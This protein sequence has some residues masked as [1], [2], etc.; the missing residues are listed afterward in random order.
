MQQAYWLLDRGASPNLPYADGWTALHE[1]ASRDNGK[2]IA[3]LIA[4]GADVAR[5]TG[6]PQLEAELR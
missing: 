6:R 3:A 2:M 1:C 5:I 4:H